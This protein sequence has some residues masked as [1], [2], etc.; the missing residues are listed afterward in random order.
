MTQI[1]VDQPLARILR[2]SE[3]GTELIDSDGRVIGYFLPSTASLPELYDRAWR[4]FDQVDFE[5]AL[6]E[7]GGRPLADILHD[8]RKSP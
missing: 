7:G 6:A 3:S 4:D 8:L 5:A 2:E 1:T